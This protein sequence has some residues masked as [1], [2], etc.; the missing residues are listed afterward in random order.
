MSFGVLSV[1]HVVVHGFF[2]LYFLSAAQ[3]MLTFEGDATFARNEVRSDTSNEQGQGGAISNPG[4]GSILFKGKLT[5]EYNK[6]EVKFAQKSLKAVYNLLY[7]MSAVVSTNQLWPKEKVYSLGPCMS[8][9]DTRRQTP[10]V[11]LLFVKLDY[12]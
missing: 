1:I 11:L 12:V 2:L 7:I 8:D 6:A 4:S 5:M 9:F 10:A 3:G